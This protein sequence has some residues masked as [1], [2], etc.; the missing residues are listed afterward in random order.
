[1]NAHPDD[2]RL[3]LPPYAVRATWQA[4]SE[5]VDWSLGAYRVPEHWRA[6]RGQGIRVAVLD[7]GIDEDHPDLRDALEAARDF[8]GSRHGPID[9]AGHGTHVAGTIGARQNGVG[10][11]GIAPECRLVVGK[12]LGDSGSGEARGVAAGIDWAVAQAADVI[13]LSLGSRQ[14]SPE[15]AGAIRR[16]VDRGRFVICAAGNEGRDRSVNFPARL[17][18][19]VAVGAVDRAGRVARFSSRGDE[20]DIAAPGED[21]LSTWLDGGY[22]KLSGTSMAAPFV[23]GIVALLLAKHRSRGGRS[24]VRNQA[25]LL[26]HLARTAVDAGPAGKDPNYGFGLIHPDSVLAEADAVESALRAEFGPVW[27]D[28]ARGRFVFVPDDAA[29]GAGQSPARVGHEDSR[30]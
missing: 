9:R 23:S 20:V 24:P 30:R 27:I 16:A 28:G 18:T 3:R 2:A 11:V 21:I 29:G 6:T 1:M 4:L 14:E 13:S 26:D 17:D 22:A 7:T 25:E 5:T 19:T 12:V 15:I 10:L 8:T